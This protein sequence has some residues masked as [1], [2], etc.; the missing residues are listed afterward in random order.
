MKLSDLGEARVTGEIT[1]EVPI[2]ALN[3]CPPEVLILLVF[4][5]MLLSVSQLCLG[6]GNVFILWLLYGCK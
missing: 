4:S 5:D 6:I 1:E 2:P 3:W